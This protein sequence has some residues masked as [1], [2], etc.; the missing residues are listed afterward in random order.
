VQ[1]ALEKELDRLSLTQ[2]LVD[3]EMATARVIDLTE[4]LVD[5]REQIVNLRSELEHLRIE[6]TQYKVEQEQMKS[7]AAF[8]LASRIWA[9]RNALRV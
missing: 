8:R 1:E 7:S 3:A 2:A 6:Y 9:V 4:R 5:A